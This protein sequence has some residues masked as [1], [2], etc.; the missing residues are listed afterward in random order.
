MATTTSIYLY[1]VSVI[2]L[3]FIFLTNSGCLKVKELTDNFNMHKDNIVDIK[4]SED[5][6]KVY[7][8]DHHT[9][10]VWDLIGNRLILK[11]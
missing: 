10:K 4:L 1:F 11:Q 3:S 9:I 2:L 6:K 5:S 7:S 8:I